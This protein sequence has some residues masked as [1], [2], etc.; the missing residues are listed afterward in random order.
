MPSSSNSDSPTTM[1]PNVTDQWKQENV[2]RGYELARRG[3]KL[4]FCHFDIKEAPDRSWTEGETG[5]TL[6]LERAR[7]NMQEVK[8]LRRKGVQVKNLKLY[9][10][11]VFLEE[12]EEEEEVAR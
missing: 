10:I 2:A 5:K 1:V 4:Y 6:T 8:D 3:H 12:I 9:S 7:Q 11:P